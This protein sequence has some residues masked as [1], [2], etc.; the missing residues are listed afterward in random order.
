MSV[1]SFP[2]TFSAGVPTSKLAAPRHAPLVSGVLDTGNKN[3]CLDIAGS[4]TANGTAA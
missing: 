2:L 4:R 1:S 3:L